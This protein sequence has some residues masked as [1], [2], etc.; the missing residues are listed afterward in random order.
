VSTDLFF[1]NMFIKI[2]GEQ[3]YLRLPTITE[4]EISKG[5]R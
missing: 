5:E 2:W 3:I 4:T 1:G